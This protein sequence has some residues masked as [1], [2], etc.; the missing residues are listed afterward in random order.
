M[1]IIFIEPNLKHE[2]GHPFAGIESLVNYT[3][4]LSVNFSYFFI[5]NVRMDN[6]LLSRFKNL[7]LPLYPG[8]CFDSCDAYTRYVAIKKI[9]KKYDLN[10]NDKII[11]LTAHTKEIEAL[12]ILAS[13]SGKNINN[14]PKITLFIHQ[15][16]KP[17]SDSDDLFLKENID[18]Q[19]FAYFS[20]LNNNDAKLFMRLVTPIESLTNKLKTDYGC[21][22]DTVPFVF[23]SNIEKKYNTTNNLTYSFLGDGRKE[24]G[25][26]T[27]L[28]LIRDKRKNMSNINFRI[29]KV[30]PRY[31]NREEK[32]EL[33]SIFNEIK[34]YK[35]VVVIDRNP[36]KSGYDLELKKVDIMLLPYDCRNYS[37]RMSGISAECAIIGIP[38]VATCG[39]TF[40]EDIQR[41]KL[42]GLCFDSHN[43]CT[44]NLYDAIINIS[45]SYKEYFTNAVSIKNYAKEYYSPKLF[46][47]RI[48]KY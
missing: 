39:T 37:I 6:C 40:S 24:K 5:G 33:T 8:L 22:V 17:L 41:N 48:L 27:I 47:E 36:T 18:E 38:V 46:F 43:K 2:F 4:N 15:Y 42:S 20:A 7:V 44:D 25:L 34:K 31:F 32:F 16:Y 3:K 14:I 30:N 9:I 28:R 21:D 23:C 12:K 19:K 26:L 10:K 1:K 11:F 45:K 13:K 29:Q 35:N